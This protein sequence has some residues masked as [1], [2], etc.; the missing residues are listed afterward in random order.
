MSGIDPN[1]ICYRLAI[2]PSIQPI[3]QKK[4]HLGTDKRE[5]FLGETQK[6]LNAGFIKKL[7]LISWLANV[8]MVKK[9]NGKWKMCVDYTDLKKACPKGA[10]PLPYI[11]KLVD[12][13]SDFQCLSFIDAYSGYNQILMYMP[14]QDKTIFITDHG[15]TYH[16]LM[17]K[18]FAS[19]IGRNIEK[20]EHGR[21]LYLYLSITNHAI[22]SVLVTEIELPEYDIQYQARGAIKSQALANFIAELT[23]DEPLSHDEIWMLYVDGA[24]NVQGSGAGILLENVKGMT[25]EQYLQFTFHASNNQAEYEALIAS[26]KLANTLGIIHLNVNHRFPISHATSNN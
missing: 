12:S 6:L 17:D 10:Y 11:D 23:L 21:P 19:Q 22:S 1:I 16:R 7:I 15:A 9:H 2:N 8:V 26:L 4:L 20:P 5:A 24:S 3:A 18:I 13:S 14:N 25:I